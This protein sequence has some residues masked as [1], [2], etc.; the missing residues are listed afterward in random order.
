MAGLATGTGLVLALGGCAR[1]LFDP[2]GPVGADDAEIL[3]DAIL[4]MLAIVIPTILLAFWMAWRYRASNT[5]AEYLPY[6]SYSG[7]IEAIVWAIPIL[8]ILFIGGVIWIG[9][10][11]LDPFK[12]LPSKTPPL[13]V[14]VV[15]LD[16]KWLFIYPRQG[17]ATV[18]RLIVP[19][20]TPIRFSITSASVFNVFF[21][22]RL[23]SMIYAMPGMVSQLN[24][25]ADRPVVLFGQSSHF[26]GDG[27]SDMQFQV[28]S[29]APPEFA[30]WANSARN[31]GP[32]LD[33]A[34]YAALSRQSRHVAP[35]TYR[36][37]DPQLFRD[38]ALRRVAPGPGPAPGA[39]AHAGREISPAGGG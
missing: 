24:L 7:R 34:A 12:P 3:I 17:I 20:G 39:P 29:V 2:V 27:F 23:G 36:S 37:V 1:S 33:Q 30:A 32:V 11:K 25:Q 4:I 8:T 28:R 14:Q 13:E 6:W 21:I 31:A 35:Y 18:N 15:S 5:K 22:P 38:I 26:S 19:A 10:Y 9:S 16:W